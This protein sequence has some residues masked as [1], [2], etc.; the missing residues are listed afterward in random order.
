LLKASLDSTRTLGFISGA[1]VAI[2]AEGISIKLVAEKLLFKFDGSPRT[3]GSVAA[4][5][6][7][8]GHFWRNLLLTSIPLLAICALIFIGFWAFYRVKAEPL[9]LDHVIAYTVITVFLLTTLLARIVAIKLVMEK[10]LS[11]E[12][13]YLP[14]GQN[15]L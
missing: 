7:W 11:K 6:L 2:L 5:K 4:V 9:G 1:F 8:W 15:D 14:R 12:V 3:I 10:L 13:S